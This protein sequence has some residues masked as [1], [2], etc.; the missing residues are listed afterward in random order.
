MS[1]ETD[2]SSS[3]PRGR[4]GSAYPPG[5]EPYGPVGGAGDSADPADSPGEA[6]AKAPDEPRTETTLTTRIRINIPGS[7]PIP[8]VVMRT[9]VS[10]VDEAG[11]SGA[12]KRDGAS[13]PGAPGTSGISS[14]PGAPS[15]SGVPGAPGAG[16][17][18]AP[19]VRGEG[20]GTLGGGVPVNGVGAPEPL[21]SGGGAPAGRGPGPDDPDSGEFTQ[22]TSDWFAPRK[23]AASKG[24][25]SGSTAKGS[26]DS[27]ISGGSGTSGDS[28]LSGLAGLSSTQG[29]APGT[30]RADLPYFS[31]PASGSGPSDGY[32]TADPY[33]AADPYD[34]GTTPRIDPYDTGATPRPDPYDTGATPLGGPFDTPADGFPSLGGG[35]G[36]DGPGDG[37]PPRSAIHGLLDGTGNGAGSGDGT[38]AGAPFDSVPPVGGPSGETTG[39][40]SGDMPLPPPPGS[41]GIPGAFGNGDDEPPV[42]STLGLGTGPA[43]FGPG[44]TVAPG[45]GQGQGGPE[46]GPGSGSGSGAGPGSGSGSGSGDE[47]VAGDTL[48]SGIPRVPASDGPATPPPGPKAQEPAPGGPAPKSGAPASASSG[49]G[50]RSKLVLAGV[51]IVGVLGIA[52][53]AG[54]LLDHAD[55]PT[56]TTV[57]GVDIG[58]TTKHEAVNKLDAALGDSTT[59]P[60]TVLAG[61][62]EA[63]LKPSVAGLTLDTEAT[64]RGA[65]G[66][67]YNPVSV[68]GSLFGGT[69][70]AEPAIKVDKEKMKSALQHVSETAGDGGAPTDGM[71]KFVRGKA[72]GVPGEPHKGVDVDKGSSV[73]EEAY[74]KR[75]VTGQNT[76]VK[77]PVS[78]QQPEVG[79]QEINRAIKEFG[80]PAMSGLVTVKAGSASIQ[81][82]P[83][84]SLPK[85][86][87]MKPVNGRLVDSYDLPVLKQLYGTTFAGVQVTRGDGSK[88]PVTPQ[89][90][91]GALRMALKETDPSKRVGEIPLN[92]Q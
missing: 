35:I 39:P 73:L 32:D 81:F 7:R 40:A 47:R 4:G 60:F 59:E 5:T 52:Y 63:K 12:R 15:A 62:K 10:D 33:G 64:V 27:G 34:T 28:S 43:P 58:N 38:G 80:K 1:R 25:P 17:P 83:E 9:P 78:M 2:S 51:G 3:G 31:D 8:P 56:G 53:G 24:S 36:Q 69:R 18:S 88:T 20:T 91:V 72:V 55:V 54:L 66:R 84:K 45:D 87:S 42:S 16:T 26:G 79:E 89:D 68:I 82:S 37:G 71:V 44:G 22:E 49:R 41:R 65:A 75:A 23:G 90:V 92:P 67:D 29:G 70:E 61:D 86:L 21:A 50:G 19:P 74:R 6:G 11:A 77:L 46:A 14:A 48:T 13:G 30:G 57:L 76:A 85:F